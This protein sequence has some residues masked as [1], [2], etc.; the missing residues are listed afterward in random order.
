MRQRS[1]WRPIVRAHF[2]FLLCGCAGRVPLPQHLA[3]S[4]LPMLLERMDGA[5]TTVQRF[6]AEARLTYL[7]PQGR[8]KGTA[9]MLLARPA[10][11]RCDVM[12][13][14]G[15]VLHAFATDGQELQALD[16][17][18][19]Q[20]LY[21]PANADNIDR[22]LPLAPLGLSP[23]AWVALLLG[24]VEVEQDATL[25]Y[26]DRQGRFVIAWIIGGEERRV[27]V[28][29]HTSQPTRVMSLAGGT[30]GSDVEVLGRD[31]AGLP[32]AVRLRAVHAGVHLELK[33]RDVER[34]AKIDASTFRLDPPRGIE[35][36]YL[37]S[38]ALR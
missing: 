7:G 15:G 4:G 23:A 18:S 26:D 32:V 38:S 36:V 25:T 35:T 13:P 2:V 33:L 34:D 5:R 16:V 8:L 22:L 1:P 3:V 12:G 14:H 9:V 11:L 21:G 31:A 20:Y 24:E 27:E 29:P 17:K 28:D 30:V 19:N 10:S 6:S 37:G